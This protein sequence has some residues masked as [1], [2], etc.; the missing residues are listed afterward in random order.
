MRE[1][2]NDESMEG[3]NPVANRIFETYIW[4]SLIEI[5]FVATYSLISLL[6]VSIIGKHVKLP[7]SNFI[8]QARSSNAECMLNVSLGKASRQGI[9]FN[10]KEIERYTFE[11]RLK[12]S[13]DKRTSK[14]LFIRNSQRE[15][16]QEGAIK[17][18]I[19]GE[20]EC[21]AIITENHLIVAV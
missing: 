12:S 21:V 11:W 6:I 19:E 3:R 1:I 9:L 16:P 4:P 18:N 15:V 10:S 2:D 17:L 7:L 5:T 14:L 20:V 8:L 13:Q